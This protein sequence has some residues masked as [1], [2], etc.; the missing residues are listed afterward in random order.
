MHLHSLYIAIAVTSCLIVYGLRKGKSGNCYAVKTVT[1]GS[2]QTF[3]AI[4]LPG[5]AVL[6]TKN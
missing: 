3:A 5:R 2:L 4:C 6:N 1:I